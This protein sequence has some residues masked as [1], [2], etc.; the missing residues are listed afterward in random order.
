LLV[1][2]VAVGFLAKRVAPGVSLGTLVLAALL[3][4]LL[5]C[6]FMI[7]GLE[8]VEMI[9]PGTTL[10]NSTVVS[11]M[12]WSHSLASGALLGGAFVIFRRNRTGAWVLFAAV[13]SH[14]LLDFASHNPDMALAP[15]TKLHLG[16]GLWN[17]IPETLAIEGALWLLALVLFVKASHSANRAA[18]YVLWI[19]AALLTAAWYNNIAGPPPDT[20][21]MGISSLI[22]FA[23]VTG[24]A[25]WMNQ[26]RPLP[27][28]TLEQRG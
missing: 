4:D 5:W 27:A 9:K 22:F 18:L 11:R 7:A 6:A 15:G 13:L 20:S 2:H 25:Y 16:L 14:W 1:G 19:V 17:S 26:L 8:G 10:M 3:P 23:L 28:G 12:D 21:R 24:W